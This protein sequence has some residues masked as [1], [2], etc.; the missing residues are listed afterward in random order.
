MNRMEGGQVVADA[1]RAFVSSTVAD[2]AIAHGEAADADA[3]RA[4]LEAQFGVPVTWL[5]CRDL[6]NSDHCDLYV[7]PA[8][9]RRM[10]IGSPR[11]GVRLL[12]VLPAVERTLFVER[13]RTLAHGEGVHPPLLE[14]GADLL[15][16]MTAATSAQ[17]VID[18]F[19]RLERAV[20]AQGYRVME[21][22]YLFL[23]VD[24]EGFRLTITY[25]NVVQDQ[26]NGQRTVYLPRYDVGEIDRR[27]AAAWTALGHRVVSIDALGPAMLGGSL[28]CLS[29]VL[30]RPDPPPTGPP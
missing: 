8:G 7:M 2:A 24:D 15:G 17:P 11:L 6:G 3:V 20:R 30:R 9:R 4:H 10:V 1:E 12:A 29:Q 26:R 5:E 18:G 21:V 22:P 13:L 23:P 16:A 28:R 27:A 25:T 14:E 19:H